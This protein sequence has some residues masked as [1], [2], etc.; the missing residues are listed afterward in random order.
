MHHIS[1]IVGPAFPLTCHFASMRST[2]FFAAR[3]HV[4]TRASRRLSC[5]VQ[6]YYTREIEH[7]VIQ[8]TWGDTTSTN[9]DQRNNVLIKS[10]QLFLDFKKIEYQQA[11][12]ALVSMNETQRTWWGGD[13]DDGKEN[14]PAGKLKKYR[15]TRKAPVFLWIPVAE[16]IELRVEETENDKGEKAEKTA[17]SHRYKFRSFR[18]GAIDGFVEE[19]YQWYLGELRKQEDSSRYLYEMQ[20]GKSSSSSGGG[21]SDGARTY[22][23]YKLSDEKTFSSLF[24]DEKAQLLQMLEHFTN[25]TGKYRIAGYPHKLGLLL[26]GPPGTGKTSLIKALAQ[27]TGRSIVNV[28]LARITTNQELMDIMFDQSYPVMGDEVPVK[29]GFKDVIFVMEDVDAAS[30]V[31]PQQEQ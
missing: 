1:I 14:T 21:D 10:L 31:M 30:K 18:K 9:Q 22:K 15:L 2:D 8:N 24:F 17:I 25:K 27:H 13:D 29:L 6:R 26:H 11:S 5:L 20:V 16:G 12:V 4:P 3:I 19:A 28:P 23:R 7:K